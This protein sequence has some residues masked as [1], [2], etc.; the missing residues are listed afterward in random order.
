MHTWAALVKNWPLTAFT[1]QRDSLQTKICKSLKR[2]LDTCFKHF[3]HCPACSIPTAATALDDMI[4]LN[5]EVTYVLIT[6]DLV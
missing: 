4:H 1:E 2:P 3:A 6:M 5:A